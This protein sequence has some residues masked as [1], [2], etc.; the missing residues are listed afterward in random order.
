MVLPF[1]DDI[2]ASNED[3]VNINKRFS[4]TLIPI[5]RIGDGIRD[6]IRD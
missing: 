6:G 1:R 5:D 2:V 4:N 3:K